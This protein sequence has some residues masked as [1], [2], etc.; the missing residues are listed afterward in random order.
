MAWTI[1]TFGRYRGKTLPQIALIDPDWFFWAMENQIFS[2]S[3]QLKEEANDI[4]RKATRIK[5]T[6]PKG[7]KAKVEYA[8]HPSLNKLAG[9]SVIPMSQPQRTSLL[10]KVLEATQSS[11]IT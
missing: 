2:R 3:P 9:V 11:N 7:S 8:I 4:R 10:D 6:G 5:V 1:V